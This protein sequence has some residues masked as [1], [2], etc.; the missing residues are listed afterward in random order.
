M[1]I[2]FNFEVVDI[3]FILDILIELDTLQWIILL[4]RRFKIICYYF[5]VI[6]FRCNAS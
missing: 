4:N 3:L 1:V 5:I 6:T 2:D